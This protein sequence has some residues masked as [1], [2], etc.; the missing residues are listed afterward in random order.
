ML[1]KQTQVKRMSVFMKVVTFL[2]C[3][4]N[5]RLFLTLLCP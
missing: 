3:L 2:Q 4:H 1:K 5:K